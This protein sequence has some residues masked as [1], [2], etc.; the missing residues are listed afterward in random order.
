MKRILVSTLVALLGLVALPAPA[1]ADL[2]MFWGASPT[3]ATRAARGFGFGITLLVVGFE[4]EYGTV[5]ENEPKGAPGMTT[6]MFNGLV[7]TPTSKTQLYLTA[8]GGFYRERYR[9][10]RETNVGTNVGGGLKLGLAGP[11]RLRLDYRVFNL[12]GSPIQK[13]SQRF[14]AGANISF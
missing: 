14:Y 10:F 11:L 7:Q 5:A 6:G 12:R 13:T 3:T 9:D 4:L 2:T 8:G 1:W